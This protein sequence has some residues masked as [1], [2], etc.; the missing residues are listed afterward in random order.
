MTLKT[1]LYFY[2]FEFI[3]KKGAWKQKAFMIRYRRMTIWTAVFKDV[4]C[5]PKSLLLA[6]VQ[7]ISL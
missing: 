3:C 7:L 5:A 1:L 2:L 6:W 4:Y